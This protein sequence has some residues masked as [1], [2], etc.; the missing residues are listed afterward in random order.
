MAEKIVIATE[1]VEKI[2][3]VFSKDKRIIINRFI[4]DQKFYI[5]FIVLSGIILLIYTGA[6]EGTQY[7]VYASLI[8]AVARLVLKSIEKY[9]PE[10]F[11][12]T[13]EQGKELV[14]DTSE[15]VSEVNK[16]IG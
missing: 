12:W 6:L 11:K 1:I 15:I 2:E 14:E 16:I 7:A 8:I 10:D 13:W 5:P 3:R 9:K 4:K